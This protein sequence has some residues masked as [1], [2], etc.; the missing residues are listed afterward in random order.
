VALV[1]NPDAIDALH[2]RPCHWILSGH[3]HGGQVRLPLLGAPFLPVR[4]REYDQ[5]LFKVGEQRLY[6]NRGLG[7]LRRVRFNCRPE[8]AVFQLTARP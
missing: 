5:G 3:T 7:Y 6:V 1:H 8:I 4:H 2:N